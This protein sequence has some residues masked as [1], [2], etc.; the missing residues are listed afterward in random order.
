MFGPRPAPGPAAQAGH[1][2]DHNSCPTLAFQPTCCGRALKIQRQ[3][4]PHESVFIS[5]TQAHK[6]NHSNSPAFFRSKCINPGRPGWD[7]L[8]AFPMVIAYLIWVEIIP[9]MSVPGRGFELAKSPSTEVLSSI[10]LYPHGARRLLQ[11]QGHAGSGPLIT[12]SGC[13]EADLPPWLM[14]LEPWAIA[15]ASRS[16]PTSLHPHFSAGHSMEQ[17]TSGNSRTLKAPPA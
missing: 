7:A 15:P 1:H 10:L 3:R 8:L 14:G 13:E 12:T 9:R 16:L 17:Q 4:Q 5:L 11:P 6:I 2:L